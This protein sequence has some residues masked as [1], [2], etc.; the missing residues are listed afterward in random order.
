MSGSYPITISKESIRNPDSASGGKD[1]HAVLIATADQR[2]MVIKRWGKSGS[3]G[4]GFK[5][6]PFNSVEEAKREYVSILKEKRKRGYRK[7]LIAPSPT[8][9]VANT[10]EEF[11]RILGVMLWPHLGPDALRWIDPAMNVTG[12][13]LKKTIEWKQLDDGRYVPAEEAP[14]I[15]PEPQENTEERAAADPLWGMI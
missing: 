6:E 15:I 5:V 1:Y 9:H 14:K 13:K 8:P 7:D 10:E 11:K 12:A 4:T 2:G 3:W